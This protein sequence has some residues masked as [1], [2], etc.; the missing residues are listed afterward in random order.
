MRCLLGSTVT[1]SLYIASLAFDPRQSVYDGAEDVLTSGLYSIQGCGSNTSSIAAVLDL[2][3]SYLE[4]AIS[5]THS[6]RTSPAYNA[7]FKDIDRAPFV[8]KI[9]QN[10]AYGT[11]V[12]P[13]LPQPGF[14]KVTS[15]VI[16]CIPSP[17]FSN[18]SPNLIGLT[19]WVQVFARRECSRHSG[20]PAAYGLY[21]GGMNIVVLCPVWFSSDVPVKPT[22][23]R[24]CIDVNQASNRFQGLGYP[25]ARNRRAW[26]LHEL[27][28]VYLVAATNKR[29]PVH[30]VYAVNSC[31]H[32]KTDDQ[33]YMPNNYVFYTGSMSLSSSA[34]YLLLSPQSK[35][36][37]FFCITEL[38]PRIKTSTTNA[39]VSPPYHS[40]TGS[41]RP[42][43][44]TRPPKPSERIVL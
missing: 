17:P 15:P 8:R 21:I 39:P 28:H 7:F 35:H 41:S 13:G 40:A 20:G 26:L 44:Q 5:D 34:I 10:I 29:V 6:T 11:P 38:M 14:D 33:R 32:L 1:A 9:L 42:H 30:E 18:P 22:S 12:L 24:P 43:Y 25:L 27:A 23:E 4:P 3:P 16:A 31:F 2:L 19:S 37:L 36:T